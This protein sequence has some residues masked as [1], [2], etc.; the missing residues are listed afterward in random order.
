MDIAVQTSL[1]KNQPRTC[2]QIPPR[3]VLKGN[4]VPCLLNVYESTHEQV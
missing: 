3:T 4:C 2:I 1:H